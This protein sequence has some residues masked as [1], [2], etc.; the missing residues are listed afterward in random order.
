MV[1][2]EELNCKKPM[3]GEIVEVEGHDQW[4]TVET[5]THLLSAQLMWVIQSR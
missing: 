3:L 5:P 4:R 1:L 2:P